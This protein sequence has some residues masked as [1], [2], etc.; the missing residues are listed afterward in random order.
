MGRCPY[1]ETEVGNRDTD[2]QG[3]HVKT[4]MQL[5][6]KAQQRSLATVGS[7][8]EVRKGSSLQVSEQVWPPTP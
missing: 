4:E 6:A 3:S 1:E 8:E 5:Q 2:R 7:Q